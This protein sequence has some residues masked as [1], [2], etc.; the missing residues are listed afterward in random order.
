MPKGTR[1]INDAEGATMRYYPESKIK[2]VAKILTT[3]FAS[4]LPGI[5]ILALYLINTTIRRIGAMLCFTAFF[6]L[7]LSVWTLAPTIDIFAATAA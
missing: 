3:V 7:V 2:S 1:T 5:V 6:A 4:L